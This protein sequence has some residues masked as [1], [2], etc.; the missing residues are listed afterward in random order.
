MS[1]RPYRRD[2]RVPVAIAALIVAFALAA[3]SSS[4]TS[5]VATPTPSATTSAGSEA[6]ASA[7][8]E[9][10][11]GSSPAGSAAA[12]RDA[13]SVVTAGDIEAAFGVTGVK[14]L[15]AAPLEGSSACVYMAAADN[16]GLAGTSYTPD[17]GGI[18]E[19]FQASQGV[20]SIPGAGDGAYLY[21]TILY[22]KKGTAVVQVT[23][24]GAEKFTPD[25]L[26]QIATAIAKAAAGRM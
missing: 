7:G 16:T 23:I 19:A 26:L 17:G 9:P 8:S 5:G 6:S 11:A 4:G 3:C 20:I 2:R 14:T 15:T 22:V 21:G 18:F 24:N 25:K 1:G 10:S 13:C 12:V